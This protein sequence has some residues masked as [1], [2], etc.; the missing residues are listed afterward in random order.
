MNTNTTTP[1]TKKMAES[2][3]AG[4]MLYV[5]ALGTVLYS[6]GFGGASI[7]V[8]EAVNGRR[9]V[10]ASDDSTTSPEEEAGWSTHVFQFVA[11]MT[12]ANEQ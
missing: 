6:S 4:V 9:V 3:V 2:I 12:M 10:A 5:V 11:K 7:R 8:E 1:P